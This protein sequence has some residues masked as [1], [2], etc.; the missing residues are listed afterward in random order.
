LHLSI[1]IYGS[2]GGF[3]SIE[4]QPGNYSLTGGFRLVS[5]FDQPN[6]GIVFSMQINPPRGTSPAEFA[7]RP[8]AAANAYNNALPYNLPVPGVGYQIP[9]TFN[10]SSLVSGVFQSAG[11]RTGPILQRINDAGYIAPGFSRPIR[12]KQ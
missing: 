2:D 4:G 11:T 10:S 9:G 5:E 7:N 1:E 8:I 3:R 12:I 6:R